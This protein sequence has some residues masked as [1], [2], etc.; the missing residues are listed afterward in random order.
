MSYFSDFNQ[1]KINSLIAT[2]YFLKVCCPD[3]FA[4]VRKINE[5]NGGF[6]I[7]F[8]N[9]ELLLFPNSTIGLSLTNGIK[10]E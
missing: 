8:F 5:A 2:L 10:E 6:I 1:E 7:P 3:Y 9:Q 4:M